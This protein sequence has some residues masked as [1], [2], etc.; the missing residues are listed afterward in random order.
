MD[1]LREKVFAGEVQACVGQPE[2]SNKPRIWKVV[3][4]ANLAEC[5]IDGEYIAK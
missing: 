4:I 5:K 1:S 3:I 2:D